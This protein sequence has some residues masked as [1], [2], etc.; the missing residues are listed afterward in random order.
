MARV[1]WPSPGRMEILAAKIQHSQPH[2]KGCFGF[3]DG[4]NIA[5]QNPRDE[6]AQNAYYN[7]WLDGTFCSNVFVFDPTGCIIWYRINSPGSWHDS[8]QTMGLYDLLRTNVFIT[9]GMVVD[10]KPCVRG[11]KE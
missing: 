6:V 2:L 5:I 9:A 3:V 8:Q 11:E 7:S 4:L 10:R 1:K